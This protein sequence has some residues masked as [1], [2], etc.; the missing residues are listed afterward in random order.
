MSEALG[1]ALKQIAFENARPRCAV[2][3]GSIS[4]VRAG[5]RSPGQDGVEVD[6]VAR[7][8]DTEGFTTGPD[9]TTATK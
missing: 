3:A 9:P 6:M 1:R 5:V 8:S 7:T 4:R 2:A